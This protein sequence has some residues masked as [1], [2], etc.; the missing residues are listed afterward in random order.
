MAGWTLN[1]DGSY[2]YELTN[3]NSAVNALGSAVTLTETVG[4]YTI[5]DGVMAMMLSP[6]L[7]NH[8]SRQHRWWSKHH[9]C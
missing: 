1:A 4:R 7:T 2:T 3:S 6:N 8:D 5:T 9:P